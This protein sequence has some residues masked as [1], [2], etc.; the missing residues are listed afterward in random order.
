MW[1]DCRGLRH[2]GPRV[3]PFSRCR[4]CPDA[5]NCSGHSGRCGGLSGPAIQNH[6]HRRR[7]AGH[8]DGHLSGWH[9]R[10]RLR[11]R[12]G[13]FWRVRLHR[14]ECVGQSQ[15]PHG[16]GRHQ[17]Y[18]PSAGCGVSG[19]CHHRHAGGGLGFVGCVRF[20]LV[21]GGQ[22]QSDARQ[23]PGQFAQPLD[24]FCLRLL[25]DL[26][27]CPTGRRHFHQGR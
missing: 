27:F 4:Q 5:G 19:R 26:N 9:H 22:W 11:D 8:S 7:G 10:H 25:A 6:R 18:W 21:F 1:F 23:E 12:R 14:H 13:A 15:R 2:L 16:P 17:R 24:R 3:D 20:L